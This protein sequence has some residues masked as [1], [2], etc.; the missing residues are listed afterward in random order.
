MAQATAPKDS[1]A[2]GPV[3]VGQQE[4]RVLM[5][6]DRPLTWTAMSGPQAL[7]LAY[8]LV[9]SAR[10]AGVAAPAQRNLF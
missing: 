9:A 5:H 8:R 6:F 10:A 7:D 2:I 4:G 1:R 3:M